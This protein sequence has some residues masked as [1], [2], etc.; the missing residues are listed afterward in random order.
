MN[1]VDALL[2][3]LVDYAGLFP[4]ASQEMNVAME[5]YAAY[6]ASSE[7]EILGR[8]ILPLDRIGEF[9]KSAAT[10][11]PVGPEAEPWPPREGAG[12]WAGEA[13]VSP[14]CPHRPSSP[15]SKATL[16]RLAAAF[17]AL[18]SARMNS[19]SPMPS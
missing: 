6:L 19:K 12:P 8:F 14:C 10:F 3:G 9:E 1:A 5:S 11:L 18:R 2:T 17:H 4:P 13:P 15:W 16:S 7:R